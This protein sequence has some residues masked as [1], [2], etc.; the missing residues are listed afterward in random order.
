LSKAI[1]QTEL[2]ALVDCSL[3]CESF[4]FNF[5]KESD[6]TFRKVITL[7]AVS[8]LSMGMLSSASAQGFMESR[9]MKKM[10][11]SDKNKDGMI[12]REEAKNMPRLEKNFDAID[13][14]KDGQLSKEELTAFRDKKNKK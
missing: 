6:M 11:E 8:A 4:V 1:N 7:V 9:A 5:S 10:E 14:N 2:A 12:S 13:T 3:S